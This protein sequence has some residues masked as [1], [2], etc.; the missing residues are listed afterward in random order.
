MN[1]YH[2]DLRTMALTVK[3]LMMTLLS[4][5]SWFKG[6]LKPI[7]LAM[8]QLMLHECSQAI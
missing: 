7:D 1:K 5:Y 2:M 8:S 4:M 6:K 3:R